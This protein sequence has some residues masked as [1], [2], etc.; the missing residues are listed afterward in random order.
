[1]NVSSEPLTAL[2]DLLVTNPDLTILAA[3]AEKMTLWHTRRGWRTELGRAT[4]RLWQEFAVPRTVESVLDALDG[5]QDGIRKQLLDS[6]ALLHDKHFLV[7][8]IA[9]GIAMT[10]GR[11]GMFD[12]PLVTL[13]E[14]LRGDTADV[15]FVG[16]PYDVGATHRPGSRFAPSGLRRVSTALFQYKASA[17]RPRG[18]YDPVA[19][20]DILVGTRLVDIGDIS[21]QVH[22]RNGESLAQLS[23]V[24]RACAAAKRLPVVLGGDHSITLPVVEGLVAEYEAIGVLH[25]DAHTDF[26]ERRVDDWRTDCHHGNMMNW[27][28]G[29]TRVALLAQYGIRQLENPR[30]EP[31]PKRRVWPG[32]SASRADHGALLAELPEELPYHVSIDIDC[33]DP[34]VLSD[35]GTPLP[36]GFGY[37]ELIELVEL[38]CRNRRIVGID[39]VEVLPGRSDAGVLIAADVLLRTVAAAVDAHG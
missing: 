1:M 24:V 19:D 20:R 36:G 33:L 4:A 23:E 27:V 26:F 15:V 32:I 12:A 30:A 11:G 8:H 35:T 31:E 14:A 25:F 9:E 34:A 28:V 17:E 29:N 6:I 3:D 37:H 16:M 13:S 18:A 21:S 22:T 38:M 7:A 10:Q 2:P 39:L 5:S